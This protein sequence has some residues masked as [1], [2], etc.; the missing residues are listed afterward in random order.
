MTSSPSPAAFWDAQAA[1][2]VIDEHAGQEGA[3]L[4]MLHALQRRFGWIADDAVP[5]IADAL[6][7]SRAEVHGVELTCERS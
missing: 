3:L 1:Q 7:W 4:P 2:D 5:A 6:N